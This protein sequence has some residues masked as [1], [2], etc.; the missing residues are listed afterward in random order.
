M[1]R[2]A[3]AYPAEII[4]AG[5]EGVFAFATATCRFTFEGGCEEG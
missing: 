2:A 4:I 1:G 3:M 5:M